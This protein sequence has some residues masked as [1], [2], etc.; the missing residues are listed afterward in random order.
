MGYPHSTDY[1]AVSWCSLRAAADGPADFAFACKPEGMRSVRF[2]VISGKD[3]SVPWETTMA[4]AGLDLH[5]D[6]G[7]A[8]V[9]DINGNGWNDFVV[10]ILGKSATAD[11]VVELQAL[12]GADGRPIWP[13]SVLQVRLMDHARTFLWPRPVV[14]DWDADG[15]PEVLVA[16]LAEP[17]SN[18]VE[19]SIIDGATGAI[20]S[21]RQWQG[22]HYILDYLQPRLVNWDGRGRTTMAI[23]SIQQG[24]AVIALWRPGAPAP[25]LLDRG[26]SAENSSFADLSSGAGARFSASM[27]RPAPCAIGRRRTTIRGTTRCVLG[28]SC[29]PKT[30]GCRASCTCAAS[31]PNACRRGP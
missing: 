23:L 21:S 8:D 11:D 16:R 22:G 12:D 31:V 27:A 15:K 6:A 2:G 28:A 14:L 1:P 17:G 18:R 20:E 19:M 9:G 7:R 10:R 25:L 24:K 13:K 26:A 30:C 3:G 4:I 5:P 29:A